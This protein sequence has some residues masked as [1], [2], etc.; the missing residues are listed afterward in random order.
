MSSF[1]GGNDNKYLLY[2]GIFIVVLVVYIIIGVVIYIFTTPDKEKAEKE[3]K[4]KAEKAEQEANKKAEQ[5]ANEKAEQEAKKKEALVSKVRIEI[6]KGKTEFLQISQLVLSDN[7]NNIIKPIK[8]NASEL[9]DSNTH[10]DVANDGNRKPR[11]FPYIYCSKGSNTDFYEFIITP[12]K[13][14]TIE[15]YNREDCCAERLEQFS[16]YIFN[17][18]NTILKTIPLSKQLVQ[19]YNI[20]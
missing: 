19:I 11:R 14:D 8:I 1:V 20:T 5:E 13:I 10:K 9:Y 17:S 15:I 3:K 16:L 6:N 2:V 4:E 12:T 18:N 7:N